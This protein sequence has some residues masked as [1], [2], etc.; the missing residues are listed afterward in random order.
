LLLFYSGKN[1][2]Q[3]ALPVKSIRN[4]AA[5]IRSIPEKEEV[6]SEAII[7]YLTAAEKDK[8]DF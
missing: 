4:E 8:R 5:I 7:N 6:S 1:F 3:P 2:G